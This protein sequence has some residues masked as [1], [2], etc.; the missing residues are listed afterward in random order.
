MMIEPNGKA[1]KRLWV[2]GIWVQLFVVAIFCAVIAWDVTHP[3]YKER[4][5]EQREY[6]K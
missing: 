3:E 5:L 6:K 2:Y 4:T 1:H